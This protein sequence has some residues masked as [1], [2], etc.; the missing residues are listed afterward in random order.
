MQGISL[1][2]IPNPPKLLNVRERRSFDIIRLFIRQ[3]YRFVVLQRMGLDPT[4]EARKEI[5]ICNKHKIKEEETDVEWI[6]V[7]NQKQTITVTMNLPSETTVRSTLNTNQSTRIP[8]GVAKDRQIIQQL[9][10]AKRLTEEFGH[11][12]EESAVAE[13]LLSLNSN[14]GRE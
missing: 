3:H 7:N 2:R 10:Y 6:D 1:K 5:R 11:T 8:K 4:T 9:E 12:T 13:M 14:F